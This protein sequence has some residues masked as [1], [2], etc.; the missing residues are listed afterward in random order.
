MQKTYPL[1]V[2]IYRLVENL[3]KIASIHDAEKFLLDSTLA[4][5]R[6]S[7]QILRTT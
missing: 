2:I 3:D 6:K 5:K 4:V 1:C 7:T